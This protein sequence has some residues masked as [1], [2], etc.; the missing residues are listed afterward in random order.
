MRKLIAL[1]AIMLTVLI[2][3]CGEH[4]YPDRIDLSYTPGYNTQT[5]QTQGSDVDG[6]VDDYNDEN[7]VCV[8]DYHGYDSG[9]PETA[10]PGTNSAQH[11][12]SSANEGQDIDVSEDI[13]PPKGPMIALTFDDGPSRYTDYILDILEQYGAQATFFV[14][15]SRI[16]RRRDTIARTVEIGSEVAGHTWSHSNLT[17]LSERQITNEIQRTS[18]AIEEI[19]GVT[20]SFF[21]PPFG[22]M[23]RRVKNVSAE[24]GYAIVSWTIDTRDWEYRCAD[25]V[26]N[27][28]MRHASENA[29]IL[30]HDIHGTTAEAMKRVIPSLIAEGYRLVTVSELLYHVYGELEEGNVYGRRR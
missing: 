29:V 23:N 19:T 8:E 1:S 13:E 28:V 11:P 24:L 26:Y 12:Q 20:Q 6:Y 5:E 27:T 15:G 21:R 17:Q 10:E 22:Q 9:A 7:D 4:P 14:L 30:L 2:A 18:A 3:G 16:E 25:T